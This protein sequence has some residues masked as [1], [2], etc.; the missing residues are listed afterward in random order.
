[1]VNLRGAIVSLSKRV[2][3]A[4]EIETGSLISEKGVE[5]RTYFFTPSGVGEKPPYIFSSHC[6]RS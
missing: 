6:V 4:I 3:M 5:K 2:K 1:M